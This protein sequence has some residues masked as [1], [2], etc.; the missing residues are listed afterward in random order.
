MRGHRDNEKD[1]FNFLHLG[2]LSERPRL[3]ESGVSNT[4]WHECFSLFNRS[5]Y[6][7]SS[8]AEGHVDCSTMAHV[9]MTST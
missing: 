8:Q 6:N 4:S 1:D 9:T 5:I 2:D 3:G 7:M